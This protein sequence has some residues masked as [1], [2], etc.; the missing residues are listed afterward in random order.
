M[1]L[2]DERIGSVAKH[3]TRGGE[4]VSF[5]MKGHME[6]KFY[7]YYPDFKNPE[8]SVHG[9]MRM[10][11]LFGDDWEDCP[12]EEFK[13][14]F[15]TFENKNDFELKYIGGIIYLIP[16]KHINVPNVIVGE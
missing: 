9:G 11:D 14:I 13:A 1:K 6:L 16:V 4:I 5:C 3:V 12:Y 7:Y 15:E 2:N 10:Y 8:L